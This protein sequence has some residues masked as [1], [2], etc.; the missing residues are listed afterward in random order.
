MARNPGAS[1]RVLRAEVRAR[2]LRLAALELQTRVELVEN[3]RA[4]AA[5][6][7]IE[8]GPTAHPG[9]DRPTSI[10]YRRVVAF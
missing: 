9:F 2:V 3:R 10:I 5:M 1:G 4:F 7:F 6:G 8:T